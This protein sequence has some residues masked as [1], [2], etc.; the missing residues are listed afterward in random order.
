MNQKG[1]FNP[2]YDLR[3]L[4]IQNADTIYWN[5]TPA[6]LNE[7]SIKQDIG[8]LADT[9]A[10]AVDTGK[11]TGRAPKD[12]YIVID[13]ITKD[14][15]DWGKINI[16]IEPGYF[17]AL[18]EKMKAYAAGKTLYARDAYACAD[19]RFRLKVRVVSELPWTSIFAYNMFIRPER[20]ELDSFEPDWNVVQFPSFL[21]DP[22]TDG[23]KNKNFAII[24]F[25]RKMIIIG[26]TGYTGEVKKGIFSVLNFILPHEKKIL[27]MHCSANM[28]E[29]GDTAV[30][31]GLSGTGKTTLSADPKRKLIGDDEHGWAEDSVFNF[32][33]GCYA[34]VINLS[35]DSEPQIWNA[36]R[37]GS[38]LENVRFFEGTRKVDFENSEVTENTRVSYPIDYIDNA[39]IPSIGN[40]PNNIFFLTCDAY[41][42]LPPISR[43]D[44]SQ[45]MFHFISGYTAKVAG[46]EEGITEPVTVF[47]SCFGAPFLP[48]HPTEYAEMLGKKMEDSEV[49]IW[50]VNTGWTGG[51]YGTGARISLKYTRAM[52]NAALEGKLDNVPYRTH[53]V[54]GLNMPQ[55]CPGVPADV[56]N[57]VNTWSDKK[58]YLKHA[59]KLALQFIDNFRKFEDRA[60]ADLKNAL[61]VVAELI[62]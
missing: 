7:H 61:P 10:L 49:K 39:V 45:A 1:I 47:S 20:E 52:I 31:F 36:I 17:D 19:E 55:E 21:A 5:L 46:T 14:A 44:K 58:D 30:F 25:T 27:S 6:E 38:L 3:K 57:P 28:G 24:N 15:V 12:R 59:N 9:G 56:L 33:G 4:D 2:D 37:F 22:E 40:T 53:P 11:F 35:A 50:L 26:G 8:F 32:E 16:A 51:P 42:V 41:G 18:W 48:L 43:L 13:E 34:K 23:T 29:N 62:K 60:S 54:F